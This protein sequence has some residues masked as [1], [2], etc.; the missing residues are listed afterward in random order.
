MNPLTARIPVIILTG[1]V[2][3]DVERHM[4]SIGAVAYLTKPP[5][6]DA[7]LGELQKHIPLPAARSPALR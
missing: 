7:L 6:F 2:D 1:K 3:T 4:L 5:E